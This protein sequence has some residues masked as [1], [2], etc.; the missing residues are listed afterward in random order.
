LVRSI[1]FGLCSVFLSPNVSLFGVPQ[2]DLVRICL[3][4]FGL[5]IILCFVSNNL[6][7][8]FQNRPDT[9]AQ[10]FAI[11]EGQSY[12][13][14]GMESDWPPFR[15]RVL[16]PAVLA[17]VS[18]WEIVPP[19]AWFVILRLASAF[20]ALLLFSLL[21]MRVA[22][23]NAKIAAAGCAWLALG[24][25]PTFNHS[26]EHPTDFP[27]VI[28]FCA[29]LWLA[30]RERK[31]A[32]L[33]VT[34]VG[35]LNHQTAAFAG[36]IWICLCGLDSRFRVRPWQI[37]FGGFLIAA[38]KVT[39]SAVELAIRGEVGWGYV[40]NGYLTVDQFVDFLKHPYASGWP[41]LLLAMLIPTVIWLWINHQ[42]LTQ[43]DLR[44][45]GAVVVILGISSVI[46]FMSELRSVFLVPHVLAVFV[47]ASAEGRTGG[48]GDR[49][50][51][52]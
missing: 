9:V 18:Q 33:L 28:F 4:S 31:L 29:A 27:D 35:S 51:S 43:T 49:Q 8:R 20:A 3:L 5:A 47:A 48:D 13:V 16:F 2:R 1:V 21:L 46:A 36:V 38:S 26:W 14:E 30:L 39:T 23:V 19:A 11:L 44:I 6:N 32:L 15:S 41:V 45:L 17:F 40:V 42:A 50:E 7:R 12:Q 52:S 24:L 25:I 34:V 22:G 37:A 10:Q